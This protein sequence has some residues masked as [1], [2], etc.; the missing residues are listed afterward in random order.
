[1]EK[2]Q[3]VDIVFHLHYR[4]VEWQRVVHQVLQGVEVDVLAEEGARYVVG[5]VLESHVLNVVEER[6]RKL[7]DALGHV[8]TAVFGKSLDDGLLKVGYRGFSVGAVI[9]HSRY[10]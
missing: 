2:L 4:T 8:E 10:F 7:V 9:L 6:F 3:R 1:M 5:D